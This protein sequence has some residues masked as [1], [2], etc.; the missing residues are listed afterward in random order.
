MADGDPWVLH[1]EFQVSAE[2]GLPR[3][4]LR[5]NALLQER[6]GCPVATAVILLRKEANSTDLTGEWEVAPPVGPAWAFRYQAV[7]VW[8][9]RSSHY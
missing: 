9:C 2:P 6:H 5:Y 7:R 4:L 1:L 3:R 8:R